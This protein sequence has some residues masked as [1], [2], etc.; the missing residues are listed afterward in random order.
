MIQFRGQVEVHA[1]V[2]T[3]QHRVR[4]LLSAR[5]KTNGIDASQLKEV[6]DQ[7]VLENSYSWS[8]FARL[9]SDKP[10]AWLPSPFVK[11]RLETEFERAPE[12]A[13]RHLQWT[14]SLGWTWSLFDTLSAYLGYA[15]T[16]EVL[17]DEGAFHY[18]FSAGYELQPWALFRAG[19]FAVELSSRFDLTYTE[20]SE[21]PLLRGYGFA[22]LAVPILGPLAL[23]A[24]HDL[25][26]LQR[27]GQAL[28]ASQTSSLGLSL[29]LRNIFQL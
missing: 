23:S 14:G 6:E 10:S 27:S 1:D 11:S 9:W 4:N 19:R 8:G 13:Y 17:D 25:F 5:Y 18:G 12:A 20:L 29:D 22:A 28:A 2:E 24:R 16:R 3:L 7:V 15:A 26:L 21:T